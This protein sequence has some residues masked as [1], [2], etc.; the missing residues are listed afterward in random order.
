MS[1]SDFANITKKRPEKSLIKPLK[2]KGGRNS[3]GVITCRHRGG[4]TKRFI[5]IIDFKRCDRDGITAKVAAIEYDPNRSARLALLH[6][7]DGIK[8]YILAPD[9]IEVGMHVMAGEKVEPE[10]GN[11]MPL[12]SMPLGTKVHCVEMQPGQGAKLARSAGMSATLMAC[13]GDRAVLMMPSGELRSVPAVCRATIGTI[14]NL[15]HSLIKVGKAGKTRYKGIRP[16]VRGSAMNPVDHPM[17][18]GEGR[19]SGGRSPKGPAGTL[20]KGGKTRN[21]HKASSQYILRGRKK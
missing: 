15:E 11:C 6:Y 12:K 4:G 16:T 17:G 8:R 18:G 9:R 1:V 13:E 21:K 7:A 3:R 5:R 10:V 2:K 19:R 20:S 14:G